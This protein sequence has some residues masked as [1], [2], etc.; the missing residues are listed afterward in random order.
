MKMPRASKHGTKI[1]KIV[2]KVKLIV[3]RHRLYVNLDFPM[4]NT[5]I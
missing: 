1:H 3:N 2:D 5:A 4:H